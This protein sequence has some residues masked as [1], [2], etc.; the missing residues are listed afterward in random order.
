MSYFR[1]P[2]GDGPVTSPSQI[3]D[4]PVVDPSQVNGNGTVVVAHSTR[5]GGITPTTVPSD[6]PWRAPGQVCANASPSIVDALKNLLGG[7]ASGGAT[8]VPTD[9]SAATTE[10]VPPVLVLGG[11]ALAAYYLFR[12]KKRRA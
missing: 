9:A 12:G 3:D 10:A 8:G 7:A 6:S 1:S 2:F 5:V 11:L 4:G